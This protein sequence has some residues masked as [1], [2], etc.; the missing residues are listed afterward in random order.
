MDDIK[1]YDVHS[2]G[3][4][5]DCGMVEIDQLGD[6]Y[7]CSDVAPIMAERDKVIAEKEDAERMLTS[8]EEHHAAMESA[9]IAENA[10]LRDVLASI[11]EWK[12][13]PEWMAKEIDA[14]LA[15]SWA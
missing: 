13:I 2:C 9:W 6:W 3:F 5:R 8:L 1:R 12:P 11:R 15:R 14:E 7:R 4:G 10:R